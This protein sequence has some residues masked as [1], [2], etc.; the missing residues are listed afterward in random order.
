[1]AIK[2]I[3]TSLSI[4]VCDHELIVMRRTFSLCGK[5]KKGKQLKLTVGE[6]SFH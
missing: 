5:S 2:Q 1:M 4:S 6:Q 3:H